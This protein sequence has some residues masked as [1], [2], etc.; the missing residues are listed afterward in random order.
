VPIALDETKAI[1]PSFDITPNV[2]IHGIITEKGVIVAPYTK[3]LQ[4]LKKEN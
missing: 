4:V 1:Y 2:L 3:N